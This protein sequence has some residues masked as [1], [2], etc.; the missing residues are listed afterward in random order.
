MSKKK[1][2]FHSHS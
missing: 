1:C 2:H